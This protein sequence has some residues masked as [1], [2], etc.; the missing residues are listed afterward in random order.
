[1]DATAT[2]RARALMLALTLVFSLFGAA[3]VQASTVWNRGDVF[4]GVGDGSYKVYTN[5]G[6]FKETISAGTGGIT[7]GCAFNA[8][9]DKLYTTSFSA[10]HVVVYDDASP[11]A[12]SLAIL[13]RYPPES[14]VF[15]S[16]GHFYVGGPTNPTIEEYDAA[17][18]L[19]DTD[20]VSADATGGPD[21]I[22]LAADQATMFFA[23]EGRDIR[24]FD[25]QADIQLANFTT[26]QG[27]GN[28]FALRLLPPGDGTGGLLVA[29]RVNIKRLD[30]SGAVV[31]TYD[32]AGEDDWFALNLDPNGTSF[33]AGNSFTQN[34]YRF[35][36]ATGA[37]ELGPINS[38][39][40]LF[41]LCL[42]G[43]PTAGI[44]SADVSVT[45]SDSPDPVSV[46]QELTYAI[47]VA[48]AGPDP[49]AGVTLSDTLPATVSLG[50]ATPSQGTCSGTATVTCALGSIAS[51]ATAT[52]TIKVTPTTDA[53]LANTATVSA[54]TADPNPANNT[55][56]EL[57]V[58][59]AAGGL[60]SPTDSTT[61]VERISPPPAVKVN[62][63]TSNTCVR[64]FDEQHD[65]TLHKRLKVDI[66]T[67][68]TYERRKDLTPFS[69]PA[70][71]IV[72]SH[73]LH[74]DNVGRVE[75]RL[76]GSVTFQADI[77]G[78]IVTDSRLDRSDRL[79]APGTRYPEDLERRGLELNGRR[80]GD[81]VTL[82]ADLRTLTFDVT[83]SS[84][85]DHI[86]V[87]T[88][89]RGD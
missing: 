58:V 5:S 63:L 24:R 89:S 8:A 17:G 85:L 86:R 11:H 59:N 30:G 29:D 51:G 39:G 7:T 44:P 36:I 2:R 20:V 61:T 49:A 74:A 57:T 21:W 77:L 72:D 84:S 76:Q 13:A 15:G 69:I 68:G 65:V 16:N 73:L 50:S 40:Q 25:V 42:K 60:C 45:K 41:G 47:S 23:S 64:L 46:G 56:A 81:V 52:V 9:L 79:G 3:P 34:F 26:L 71:T 22:D 55:D 80:H 1:M 78:V 53:D 6:T 88:A 37:T 35:D 18:A 38:G 62:W 10:G 32:L 66:S 82:S 48:N 19:V 67:A 75:V 87:I 70:G 27:S 33:W 54:T 12:I 43:E 14:V 28:A 4:A 31:Q 83:F